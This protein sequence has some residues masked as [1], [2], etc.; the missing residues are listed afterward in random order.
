M[1]VLGLMAPKDSLAEKTGVVV[2]ARMLTSMVELLTAVLL[3]RLLTTTD[4]AI[5][6]LLLTVYET[7]KYLAT[8][9]FP[10]SVFYF[11][12]RLKG[13]ARTAFA[14]QTVAIMGATA[15]LSGVAM[16]GFYGI[17]DGFLSEWN[18]DSV[19]KAKTLLP[20]MAAIALLEI[21]TWP[22][23]N[24]MLASDR[25]REA[26][27]YQ[28]MNGALT[29]AAMVVPL[30]L[31]YELDTAIWSLLGYSAVRFLVSALWMW[32]VLPPDGPLRMDRALLR[33]Q[34]RFSIPIG[35]SSLVGRLNKYADKYIVAWFL[36][37][38][39]LAQ[40]NVGA[41]ELPIVRVIPF[42]VG[43][44]L[45][46]RFVQ[47]QLE[48]KRQELLDLW[49]KGVEKVSLIV[50]PL[51][52]LFIA[53]AEEFVV[54]LFGPE[55]RPAV[56]PFRLYTC[57]VL[58]RVTHYGSMLQAFGDTRG[59]M[60]MSVNLLVWNVGLSIPMTWMFGYVGTA[61]AAVV[62]NF[63]NWGMY[64]HLIGTHM[65][66]PW[67]R[68]LPFPFYL[69]VV[70]VSAATAAGAW[71]IVK[72]LLPIADLPALVLGAGI[73]LGIFVLIGSLTGIVTAAD[74]RALADWL[75]LRFLFG[76]A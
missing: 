65:R 36:S 45:I 66:L 49:Y 11:L 48:D 55:Y 46:S 18:P 12:E 73:Y 22:V 24:L 54:L 39:A 58:V 33:E 4:W 28:L 76:R 69:R 71:A 56:V 13:R 60:R 50:V 17:M 5:V 72:Y 41:Q 30:S 47:M 15:A 6:S 64:L 31:G 42:A 25:Q 8:L 35:L 53:M 10:E 16:L 2:F 40:Y 43:S 44:V 68:V 37:E 29:F 70:G 52:F 26:G 67:Y 20:V 38:A 1:V 51:A 63:I 21:P 59:I 27:W 14:Y 9:G 32:R 34:A 23:Q 75:R 62:A 74:R 57:I 3:V 19:A 7:A 61:T